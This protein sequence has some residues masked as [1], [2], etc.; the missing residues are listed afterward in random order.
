[1][2]FDAWQWA[3]A[4]FG[5]LLIGLS[6]TGIGGLGM[7]FVA[8]FAGLM[9]AKESS[10]FVLPMLVAA[11]V[12]AVAAYRRHAQWRFLWRLF[13]W[14]ALGVVVGYLAMARIDDRTAKLLVGVIVCAM[15]ALH[16][17]R[18]WRAKEQTEAEHGWWFAPMVGV[19]A[20]F[21]TLIAN[22]AGPLMAIYL[23]AM[24]LPKMEYMGTGAVYFLL[25][26]AFKVPFMVNLGLING[27][28]VAGN[29]WLLPA[30]MAGAVA[31]RAVLHRINQRWFENLALA[32]AVAAGLNLLRQ[33]WHG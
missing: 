12:V 33:S 20:G 31:G 25:M 26:N 8:I 15:V 5:A 6:K 1:M 11:D 4:V 21:T 30:V 24:R 3:L 18:R 32:L 2:N 7:L 23:L 19:L 17:F 27:A 14:T 10:G 16:I 22:A 28:S 13:P 9:P 29:L